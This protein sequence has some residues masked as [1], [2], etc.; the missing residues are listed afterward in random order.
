MDQ[1]LESNDTLCEI[2]QQEAFV[3]ARGLRVS[4]ALENKTALP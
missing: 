1:I 2:Y 3:A 4:L